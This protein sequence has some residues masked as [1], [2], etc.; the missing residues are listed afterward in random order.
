M[1]DPETADA[2]FTGGCQCGAVRFRATMLPSDVSYCHCRMCQRAV[3]N[4]FAVLAMFRKDRVEWTRGE[5]AVFASSSAAERG[6]CRACGTPL[7]FRDKASPNLELTVGSFD[8]PEALEPR[9]HYG[10]ESR[11]PWHV[12]D[13]ALPREQTN[14]DSPYLKGIR[15]Y[16]AP[17]DEGESG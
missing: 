2:E 15:S 17:P 16:Q 11:V 5:P 12:I 6:F 14:T 3:G 4:L 13:D 10:I 9:R 8:H 7:F 1:S